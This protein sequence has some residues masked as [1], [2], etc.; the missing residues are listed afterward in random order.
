MYCAI[1]HSNNQTEFTTEMMIHFSGIKHIANPGILKCTDLTVC[2]DCGAARFA[3]P[4]TQLALLAMCS[5]KGAGSAREAD[6]R[7]QVL[8]RTTAA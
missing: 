8:S 6:V 7:N 1:C 2:L 4:E 3:I 5:T